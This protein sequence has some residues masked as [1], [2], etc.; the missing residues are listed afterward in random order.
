MKRCFAAVPFLF[1][2]SV[3]MLAQ[4][5]SLPSGH[6]MLANPETFADGHVTAL[7]Q[8]VQL[9]AEQKP[10]LRAV[11]LAEGKQLFALLNDPK[12]TQE[13]KQIGIENLHQQTA[14]KVNSMLTAEQRRRAAPPEERPV[15]AHSSQT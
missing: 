8:R 1:A 3:A 2:M 13:Q 6:Q 10:K 9:T 15:P 11:F 5:G 14:D 4:T 7:D 12:L